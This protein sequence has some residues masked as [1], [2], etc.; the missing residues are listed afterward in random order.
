VGLNKHDA[1]IRPTLTYDFADGFEILG[2]ANIFM[3]DADILEGDDPGQFG[4]FDDN[5]MLY[6]KV[7][8][9]F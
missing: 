1:L 3:K 8:Y 6:L 4:Y 9:S 2:G 5:D 7:K